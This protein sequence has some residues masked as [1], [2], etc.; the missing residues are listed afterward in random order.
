M[1]AAAWSVQAKDGPIG[2][3]PKCAK[4]L[5]LAPTRTLYPVIAERPKAQAWR[6]PAQVDW[7]DC[8]GC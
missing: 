8:A 1:N 7:I 2:F 4:L 5:E 6:D 3:G